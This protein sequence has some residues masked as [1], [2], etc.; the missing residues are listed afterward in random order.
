MVFFKIKVISCI[1][2]HP[3]NNYNCLENYFKN[4]LFYY[5]TFLFLVLQV[6]NFC[7]FTPTCFLGS[8]M[9]SILFLPPIFFWGHVSDFSF[10]MK[11][12]SH[13]HDRWP[14][15]SRQHEGKIQAL[16]FSFGKKIAI[17]TYC[18]NS[19]FRHVGGDH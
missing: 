1:S 15:V 14:T 19:P 3:I 2:M 8:Q 6:T 11:D 4:I 7:D 17:Q 10:F 18:C 12:I 9:L 5:T 13:N 16:F